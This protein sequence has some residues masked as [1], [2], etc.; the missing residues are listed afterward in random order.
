MKIAAVGSGKLALG[1][2]I[3]TM[4][5]K[6]Q[7]RPKRRVI[8]NVSVRIT[9]AIGNAKRGTVD[10]VMDMTPAGSSAAAV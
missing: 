7:S 6:P 8:V 10:I 9:T 3:R 4:Q 1:P 2:T 5:A